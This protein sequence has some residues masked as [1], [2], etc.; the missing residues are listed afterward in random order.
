MRPVGI[1]ARTI[2][3]GGS[4]IHG[5][6][7]WLR[8]LGRGMAMLLM[9]SILLLLYAAPFVAAWC[10]GT[11]VSFWIA[12]VTGIDWMVLPAW[13]ALLLFFCWY[14]APQITPWLGDCAEALGKRER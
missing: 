6:D 9:L 10:V 14:V 13:L 1:A 2:R 12:R 7:A 5:I 8:D 11:K 3:F 4:V